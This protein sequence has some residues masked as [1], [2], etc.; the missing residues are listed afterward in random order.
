MLYGAL[1]RCIVNAL[2]V[3]QFSIESHFKIVARVETKKIMFFD[4]KKQLINLEGKWYSIFLFAD[5]KSTLS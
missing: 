5:V 3:I 4:K 1:K 2:F